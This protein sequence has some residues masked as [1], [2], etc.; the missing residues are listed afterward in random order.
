[1]TAWAPPSSA[2][3]RTA[4]A[5]RCWRRPRN[6]WRRSDHSDADGLRRGARQVRAGA[7]R[8]DA[9][10]AGH[11]VEDVLRL[12]DRVRRGAEHAGVP[13]VPGAARGAAGHE[14]R[15]DRG[16]HQDRPG[17]ELRD[18]R[19]V[20][21]RPEELLLSGHAEN[22][23]ISQYDEPLCVDGH[24]DVEV[25]GETYRIEIERVHREEDTGKSLRV[26]GATGRIH[27]AEYSLVDYNRA[28]IPLVEIVTRPIVAT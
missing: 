7:R 23:Q 9:H 10:R 27:G 14:P 19:V 22:Y 17:A 8:R 11:R 3:S 28:G 4:G 2:P 15:R 24:L 25:D 16:H 12:R 21:V 18:R 1:C 6:W 26:G 20:P 13:G 5:A